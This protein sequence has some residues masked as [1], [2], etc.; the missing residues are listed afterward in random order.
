MILFVF[1]GTDDCKI[2]DTIKAL[3]PKVFSEDVVCLY[4]NNI[5]QLYTKMKSSDPDP[6]FTES[7][8]SVLKER[9]KDNKAITEAD[10][11]T[12]S[13]IYLF[14]DFDPHHRNPNESSANITEL[15]TRLEKMLDFFNDE[16]ENGKLYVS[17]PMVE[18]L[19]YTKTLPDSKFAL[20]YI[21][22]QDSK[23][24]KNLA[25][26]YSDYPSHDF[27]LFNKSEL[28]GEKKR[29]NYISANWK[30]IINQNIIKA[31]YICTGTATQPTSKTIV[32]QRQILE[33]QIKKY[34][35][36]NQIAILSAYP[37]FLFEYTNISSL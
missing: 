29:R 25:H 34:I 7:L 35:S 32:G 21:N 16:T 33:K 24:F 3:Y 20:C 31:N 26:C 27:L 28:N 13:Q 10:E 30:H 8:L 11:D 19:F 22:L 6:S 37:L 5:Y 2:M 15:N 9:F 14:F 1:E 17:Y 23:N 36:K 12:F 18:A 4:Q